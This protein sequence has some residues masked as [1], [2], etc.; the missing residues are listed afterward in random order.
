MRSWICA[1]FLEQQGEV[2]HEVTLLLAF[3]GGAH[4]DAHAVGDGEFAQDLLQALAFLLVLDLARDA[5]LVGVGQQHEVT[6]GQDEVGGDARAFGA[7]RAFGD[8]HDDVA[9][10]RIEARD[11]LL[12]DLGLVAPAAFALDDFHAAVELFGT[13]SQ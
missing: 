1:P 12:R 13:M 8:L 11:V 9:A 6:A 3:A 4:D 7:D 2:A 10:G 5:A